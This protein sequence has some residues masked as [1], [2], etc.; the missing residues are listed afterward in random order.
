MLWLILGNLPLVKLSNPLEINI[1][2]KWI[3]ILN[4]MKKPTQMLM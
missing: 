4:V 1:G 2:E 3:K